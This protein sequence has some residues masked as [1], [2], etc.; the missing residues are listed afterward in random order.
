M[1]LFD[2]R[3]SRTTKISVPPGGGDANGLSYTPSLSHNGNYIAFSS[4]ATNLVPGDPHGSSLDVFLWS[5]TVT[6]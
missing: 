3:T 6:P 4:G 5:R 1:Y 2:R